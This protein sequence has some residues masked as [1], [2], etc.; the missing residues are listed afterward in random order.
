MPKDSS[1]ADSRANFAGETGNFP[2]TVRSELHSAY[3]KKERLNNQQYDDNE[4]SF[5]HQYIKCDGMFNAVLIDGLFDLAQYLMN[6]VS[7]E[8]RYLLIK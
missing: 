3:L 8:L 7:R 4:N 6:W 5:Y 2:R 1:F